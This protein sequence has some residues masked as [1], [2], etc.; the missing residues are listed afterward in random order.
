MLLPDAAM[1]RCID[2]GTAEPWCE[3]R[4]RQHQ[5]VI[6]SCDGHVCLFVRDPQC[7]DMILYEVGC[8]FE[9]LSDH[10]EMESFTGSPAKSPC[11]CQRGTDQV[12]SKPR[13][14]L[15]PRG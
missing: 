14:A 3:F 4:F 6:K 11:R 2:G 10:A 12:R 8:H 5:L 15:C 1:V 13:H 7:C 9:K